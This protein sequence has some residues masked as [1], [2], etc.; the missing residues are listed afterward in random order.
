ML[1]ATEPLPSQP[2]LSELAAALRTLLARLPALAP[3]AVIE[4]AWLPLVLADT[5]P[6]VWASGPI[7]ALVRHRLGM[8]YRDATDPVAAW[9]LR[10]EHRPGDGH[11]LGFGLPARLKQVV[12]ESAREAGVAW[13]SVLPAWAWGLDRLRPQRAWPGRSGWWVWPEQDRHLVARFAAGRLVGLNPAA[14]VGVSA[15]E[16]ETAIAHEALRMG[17]I[18]V[19]ARIGVATWAAS[20]DVPVL[21]PVEWANI[22]AGRARRAAPAGSSAKVLA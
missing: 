11:A 17:G 18:P 8:N 2:A 1:T 14:K 3:A 21:G 16:I 12:M 5:G 10:V 19:G 7:E 6:S 9:D 20:A 15:S 22:P 4:S 13:T